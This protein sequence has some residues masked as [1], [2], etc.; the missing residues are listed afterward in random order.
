MLYIR[1]YPTGAS[2]RTYGPDGNCPIPIQ[3]RA[4]V[5]TQT[6]DIQA[7]YPALERLLAAR[8]REEREA[9][10]KGPGEQRK[11]E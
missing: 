9:A 7:M 10:E 5:E 6:G 4:F 11:Q 2:T 1:T 8:G 3:V